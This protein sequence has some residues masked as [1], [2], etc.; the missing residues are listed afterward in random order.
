MKKLLVLALLLLLVGCTESNADV[1]EI[2][3]YPLPHE[4]F[5][6]SYSDNENG[7]LVRKDE[8]VIEKYVMFID[9]VVIYTL[10]GEEITLERNEDYLQITVIPKPL[11]G[12]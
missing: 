8:V 11:I 9:K 5:K 6:A 4:T 3:I 7:S 1:T 2:P 12:G 10:D